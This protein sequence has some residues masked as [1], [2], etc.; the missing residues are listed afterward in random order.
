MWL[1]QQTSRWRAIR[2]FDEVDLPSGVSDMLGGAGVQPNLPSR[3]AGCQPT[4]RQPL[5]KRRLEPLSTGHPRRPRPAGP[6]APGDPRTGPPPPPAAGTA[7]HHPLRGCPRPG[8]RRP[9]ANAVS[10]AASRGRP[11][12]AESCRSTAACRT[13]AEISPANAAATPGTAPAQY[14]R[15]AASTTAVAATTPPAYPPAHPPP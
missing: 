8:S 11:A 3:V 4:A 10:S 13:A 14:P 12:A 7:P 9:A 15:T 5:L 6:P 1:R 2:A